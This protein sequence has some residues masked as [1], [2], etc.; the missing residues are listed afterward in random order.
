M[1]HCGM[2]PSQGHLKG[3]RLGT[4]QLAECYLGCKSVGRKKNDG[5]LVFLY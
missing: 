1:W 4:G 3:N 5:T 2:G